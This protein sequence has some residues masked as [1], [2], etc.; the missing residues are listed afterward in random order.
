M[1]S[2]TT[3][4]ITPEMSDWIRALWIRGYSPWDIRTELLLSGVNVSVGTVRRQCGLGPLSPVLKNLREVLLNCGLLQ[5]IHE[6]LREEDMTVR[7]FQ[8]RLQ[9]SLQVQDLAAIIRHI[10]V[11]RWSSA[12]FLMFRIMSRIRERNQA[13]RL[14][15]AQHWLAVQDN[16]DDVIFSDKTTVVLPQ[17][18][19]NVSLQVWVA[20]SRQGVG[21]L[22]VFEG[23]MDQQ[24]YEE[25]IIKRCLGPYVRN[26]YKIPHR[27]FQDNDPIHQRAHECIAEERINWVKTPAESPD[28]NPLKLAWR[29]MKEFVR[30]EAKPRN[31]EELLVA[32]TTFW[33]DRVTQSDCNKYIDHLHQVLPAVIECNGGP[34]GL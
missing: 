19:D 5:D 7:E 11:E 16:F 1:S 22:L 9:S 26:I 33:E 17:T 2:P 28:F 15:F 32:L 25:N 4:S 30:L 24:F 20:I 10:A 12:G 8:R 21:A 13:L 6:L 27:F 34:T 29:S 31:K 14:S 3:T 23:Y 18:E